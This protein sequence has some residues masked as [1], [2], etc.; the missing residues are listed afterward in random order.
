MT[1]LS[2]FTGI[3]EL[4]LAAEWAAAVLSDFQGDR[5][6]VAVRRTEHD[7]R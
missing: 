7:N 1:H 4:D 3:G 5:R 6:R 2:L